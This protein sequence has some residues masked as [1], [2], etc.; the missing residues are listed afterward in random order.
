MGMEEGLQDGWGKKFGNI[1]QFGTVF[2]LQCFLKIVIVRG[3]YFPVGFGSLTI[4][5]AN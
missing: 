3:Q 2:C 4:H 1:A 5:V